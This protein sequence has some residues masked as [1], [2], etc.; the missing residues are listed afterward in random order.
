MGASPTTRP[1]FHADHVGSLL[2]PERLHKARA[3]FGK[4]EITADALRKVEDESIEAIIRLQEEVG[5]PTITDGEFRRTVWWLEFIAAIDGI[6]IGGPDTSAAFGGEDK[7]AAK[8]LPKIVE[9]RGKLGR[10]KPI[11]ARDYQFIRDHTRAL[12]KVTIPSPS[13]IHF[14][15]GR[16]A[17][18]KKTYPTLDAFWDDIVTVYRAEIAALEADGCRFIQIDDPVL[19]YFLEDRIHDK[20]KDR[21]E[22]PD[23]TLAAYVD[24]LNRI[25]AGRGPKTSVAVHVCRGNAGNAWAVGGSY[26]RIAETIFP[27]LACDIMLLEYDDE[28]SGDFMPLKL[29][30]KDK[31]VVLGLVTTK[32]GTM[33]KP[34]VLRRRIDEAARFLPM[35]NLAISP[36]CGFA[37]TV[38]GNAILYDDEVAKLKLVVDTARAV[39]GH[40]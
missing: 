28:R 34:D 26:T 12:P 3:Q 37:S 38:G 40:V 21:G 19:C 17:I 13:R 9:T 22:D 24:V 7:E 31:K 20:L 18:D 30:P 11:M 36:Q 35:E 4:G 5:L 6:A 27:K 14:H 15:G 29:M 33:E 32:H 23:A 16:D 25:I 10:S 2:R 39:W 8:Y 1:F